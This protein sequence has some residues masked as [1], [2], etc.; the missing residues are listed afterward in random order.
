[1][2]D[3]DLDIDVPYEEL[4]AN[5]PEDELRRTFPDYDWDGTGECNGIT[6]ESDWSVSY[7]KSIFK[8]IPCYYVDH[9]RIEH[10]FLPEDAQVTSSNITRKDTVGWA[11]QKLH[12]ATD[13]M[14]LFEP[15]QQLNADPVNVERVATVLAAMLL[16]DTHDESEYVAKDRAIKKT[17]AE[18]KQIKDEVRYQG[19]IGALITSKFTTVQKHPEHGYAWRINEEDREKV[20]EIE[21][22]DALDRL[23]SLMKEVL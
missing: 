16:D 5:V 13:Q 15:K 11:V 20:L 2:V 19:N 22:R 4:A 7:H 14:G 17:L 23:R 9:S 3:H 10:I 6:L 12:L 21:R 18:L 1:M 8:G